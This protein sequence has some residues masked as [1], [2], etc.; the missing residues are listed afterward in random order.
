MCDIVPG[1]FA[2]GQ[3]LF[4][5]MTDSPLNPQDTDHTCSTCT[6]NLFWPLSPR[7]RPTASLLGQV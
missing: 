2:K 1:H 4:G 5:S 7:L 6:A 3:P